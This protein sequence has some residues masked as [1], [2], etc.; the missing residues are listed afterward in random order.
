MVGGGWRGRMRGGAAR[1][2]ARPAVAAPASGEGQAVRALERRAEAAG[3]A[4]WVERRRRA[5]TA[6]WD[7]AIGAAA[8]MQRRGGGGGAG[9]G[10]AG[11]RAAVPRRRPTPAEQRQEQ[12]GKGQRGRRAESADVRCLARQKGG[13]RPGR[14]SVSGVVR[15]EARRAS[16]R[17]TWLCGSSP[18]IASPTA[19]SFYFFWARSKRAPS[20]LPS[21]G[22]EHQPARSGAE[23]S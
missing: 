21:R 13:A 14:E 8:R 22:L 17:K 2:T 12:R 23:L 5:E 6:V 9:A 16:W 11:G 1:G 4:V 3:G 10:D 7:R 20:A 19:T 18:M 15:R